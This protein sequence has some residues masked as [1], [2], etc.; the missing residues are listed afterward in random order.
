[1]SNLLPAHPVFDSVS[2]VQ[3]GEGNPW[4]PTGPGP[5]KPGV[6]LQR[7]LS[8]V[9][10]R[11]WWIVGAAALGTAGG[12]IGAQFVE[13]E[14]QSAST[15][16]IETGGEQGGGRGPIRTDELLESTGWIELL[17]SYMVLDH[18]VKEQRLYL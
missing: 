16:W 2:P 9:V 5:A 17:K 1:M 3:G 11:K 13:P 10:R 6:Q 18:V 4:G 14:Y 7:Y 8:A 12:V 15:L